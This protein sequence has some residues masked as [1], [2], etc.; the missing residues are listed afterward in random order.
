MEKDEII[1]DEEVREEVKKSE[2]E[3]SPDA[4][5]EPSSV[6]TEESVRKICEEV[7]G[8]FLDRFT[9]SDEEDEEVEEKE[10]DDESFNY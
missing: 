6:L 7:I 5:P 10:V 2:P 8:A 3:A 1:K 4:S 9:P